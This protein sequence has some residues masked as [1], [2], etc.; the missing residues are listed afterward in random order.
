MRLL[1]FIG[2][3]FTLS[4]A[5]AQSDQWKNVYTESAWKE[6]D[7]WQRPADLISKMNISKGAQ[8]ADIGCHEG[9][10]SFKLA[11][12]VGKEGKVYAVD[13]EQDK[14]NKLKAHATERKVNNI[15]AVKGDYDNPRLP[16]NALDAVIII[17]TYHEMDDHDEILS[18][19]HRALKAGGRL[20]ICEPIADSRKDVSRSQQESKHELGMNYALEDLA[21]AGF[22]IVEK[23]EKFIDRV[24]VKGDWMW[25]VVAVK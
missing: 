13:V 25:L 23:K 18:H 2:L 6:R 1:F 17:D 4:A 19:V 21:K 8:V 12:A 9:Y 24:K 7:E 15:E 11:D 22:R 10:M 3:F 5:R 16:D 14:L 20:V